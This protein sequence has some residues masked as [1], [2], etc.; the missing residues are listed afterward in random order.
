M[1]SDVIVGTSHIGRSNVE[2]HIVQKRKL[3]ADG[4]SM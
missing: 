1:C 4:G 3:E 2:A